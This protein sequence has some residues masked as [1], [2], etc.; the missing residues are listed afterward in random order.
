MS[1]RSRVAFLNRVYPPASGATGA[2]LAELAP[3]LVERGWCVTVLTGPTEGAPTS[4][5]TGEGVHVERVSALSFTR[6]SKLQRGL[7]YAPLY[8][9]FLA[10]ALTIPSPDGRVTKTDLLMLKVLGPLL[11]RLTGP[12]RFTG[13]KTYTR[14]SPRALGC[15]PR[16]ESYP[17]RCVAFPRKLSVDPITSWRWDAVCE[18]A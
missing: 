4:E 18:S 13:H 5:I 3:T 15:C 9:G 8:P 11:S 7:A 1:G 12:R 6:E 2:L 10:C 16:T 17:E 14:R